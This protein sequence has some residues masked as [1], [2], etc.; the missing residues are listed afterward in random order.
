MKKINFSKNL[1]IFKLLFIAIYNINFNIISMDYFYSLN[2]NKNTDKYAYKVFKLH[3]PT[4]YFEGKTNKLNNEAI[5]HILEEYKKLSFKYY[6]DKSSR[7]SDEL[8]RLSEEITALLNKAK[9]ELTSG[10]INFVI[11]NYKTL[12]KRFDRAKKEYDRLKAERH[13][14]KQKA[15]YNREKDAYVHEIFG[16]AFSDFNSIGELYYLKNS[17]KEKFLSRL[18]E[19]E[20][21]FNPNNFQDAELKDLAKLQ[22]DN[23]IEAGN[24]IKNVMDE[25]IKRENNDSL[26][27]FFKGYKLRFEKLSPAI[28][29]DKLKHS[30]LDMQITLNFLSSVNNK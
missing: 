27:K 17:S 16:I 8:K 30:L 24:I 9:D 1:L 18:N 22:L 29:I 4:R 13:K 2:F 20:N 14:R 3:S 23:I 11:K 15:R 5:K 26:Y 12:T 10:N 6:L 21:K 28:L 7:Y 19:L 25:N